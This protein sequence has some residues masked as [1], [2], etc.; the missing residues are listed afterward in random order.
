MT[1]VL[2]PWKIKG[3][4]V[5]VF[6]EEH[7]LKYF[8]GKDRSQSC[9]ISFDLLGVY[10]IKRAEKLI[11]IFHDVIQ[12]N[13]EEKIHS[14][15]FLPL[16]LIEGHRSFESNGKIHYK[17]HPMKQVALFA[18]HASGNNRFFGKRWAVL[19]LV[20]REVTTYPVEE[21][22]KE[23][24]AFLTDILKKIRNPSKDKYT[25]FVKT[26][27][28]V[29][30]YEGDQVISVAMRCVSMYDSTVPITERNWAITVISTLKGHGSRWNK[31]DQYCEPDL[32]P[33]HA[34]IA[35]EGLK[36]GERYT[37]YIHLTNVKDQKD[38]RDINRQLTEA[39]VEVK[40]KLRSKTINGPTWIRSR[41][42]VE[43]MLCSVESDQINHNY[44]HFS[45]LRDPS[46]SARFL[47]NSGIA[48]TSIASLG[49][50]VLSVHYVTNI[51]ALPDDAG[52]G[53]IATQAAH[54]VD[55]IV[56]AIK[57]TLGATV[58]GSIAFY[59]GKPSIDRL[60][61]NPESPHSCTSWVRK[62]LLEV[63]I[64]IDLPVTAI[65]PNAMVQSLWNEKNITFRDCPL[66]CVNGHYTPF[67]TKSLSS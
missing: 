10:G 21:T 55:S 45:M 28:P 4:T 59:L 38:E 26:F 31:E 15:A 41:N 65:T 1:Q 39:R 64:K 52:T 58:T 63:G 2:T 47:S 44:Y 14:Q 18:K 57:W 24:Y 40:G 5:V 20:S 33:S 11:T 53:F 34:M 19:D 16:L 7:I 27:L 6:R 13:L 17:P 23:A 3:E 29:L 30:E 56:N 60:R 54:V 61:N 46:D 48:I 25:Q 32:S 50:A 8:K 51:E 9:P 49:L 36:E 35:C 22:N 37:K 42:L 67:S 62:Q 43:K 12:A 66:N